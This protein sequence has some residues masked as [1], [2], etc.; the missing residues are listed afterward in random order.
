VSAGAGAAAARGGLDRG[1]GAAEQA[2]RGEALRLNDRY[3]REVVLAFG[4]CPW[5][6]RTIATGGLRR[7]VI[8]DVAPDAAAALPF[9]DEMERAGAD[10]AAIGRHIFPR[11]ALDAAAFDRFTERQRPAHR[12]RRPAAA[13][14]APFVMAA[15]HPDAAAAFDGPH[16]LVSF[17]RRTPD[18]TIQLVR[19]DL[20]ERARAG[21]PGISDEIARQNHATVAARGVAAVDDVVRAIRGDRDGS[22][23]ALAAT[24]LSA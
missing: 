16:Q 14:P 24:A 20:L 12:A 22:Y 10:A 17:L 15:F 1:D 21:R 19:L 13:G 8:A 7:A 23:A 5:A 18:P 3:L 4:L 9:I 2:L 11:A 6:D